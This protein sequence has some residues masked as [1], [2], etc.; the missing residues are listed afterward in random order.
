FNN[1][2]DFLQLI[3]AFVNAPLF[4][5]FIIGMFWKR[6]TGNGAFWGLIAG[7][8]AAAVHHGLTLA[9]GKGAWITQMHEY[10]SGMA[11]SFWTAIFA[12]AACFIVTVVVSLL[13]RQLKSKDD[14]TGLVYSLTPRIKDEPGIPWF[15]RPVALAVVVGVISIVLTI[16]LR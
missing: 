1:I 12:F 10:P 2:M 3:F 9:E 4:A 6:A 11:Q 8:F 14:L 16:L 15:E 7:T 13:T 5:T